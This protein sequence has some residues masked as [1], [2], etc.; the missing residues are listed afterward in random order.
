MFVQHCA[1]CN[2]TEKEYPCQKC[3]RSKPECQQ[4]IC[5]IFSWI[6]GRN[7]NETQTNREK[8]ERKVRKQR[9]FRG[10]KIKLS[11]A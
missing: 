9:T 8:R 10:K 5:R 3:E 4:N 6:T 11:C 7:E 2:L 1:S